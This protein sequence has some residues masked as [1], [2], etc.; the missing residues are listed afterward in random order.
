MVRQTII[1]DVKD[2]KVRLTISNPYYKWIRSTINN[3]NEDEPNEVF[4]PL[5]TED[6][7]LEIARRE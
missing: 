2:S 4:E 6:D 3:R 7:G 5:V 1:V